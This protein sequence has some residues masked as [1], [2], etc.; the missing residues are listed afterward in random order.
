MKIIIHIDCSIL[1]N[2]HYNTSSSERINKYYTGLLSL[3]KYMDFFTSNNIDLLLVDNTIDSLDEVPLI[4]NIIP[5]NVRIIVKRNNHYGKINKGAGC[6]EHWIMGKDIWKN[7]DY[8]IH[9]EG[10]QILI[11]N[12]FMEEFIKQPIS[13]FSWAHKKKSAP[14]GYFVKK[15]KKFDLNLFGIDNFHN[16]NSENNDYYTG[17]FAMDICFFRKF[18]EDMNLEIMCQKHTALE[19]ALMCF[20]YYNIDNFRMVNKTYVWR[21]GDKN[22]YN[23]I[24]QN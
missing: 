12:K 7:Y 1:T 24:S 23:S 21:G 19:K 22:D 3:F 14:S 10:R 11:N 9:F 16:K 17:I 5:P 18:I 8:L 6:F 2:A 4:K 13:T 15:D 20:T